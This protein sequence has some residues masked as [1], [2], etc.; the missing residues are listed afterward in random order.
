MSITAAHWFFLDV[1]FL[2]PALAWIATLRT[3]LIRAPIDHDEIIQTLLTAFHDLGGAAIVFLL[4]AKGEPVF[5][6]MKGYEAAAEAGE[7]ALGPTKLRLMTLQKN[8]LQKA[9]L[10][11]WQASGSNGKRPLDGIIMA[12]TPW[13]A[14][15]LG[16]TQKNTYVGYTGVANLLGESNHPWTVCQHP[17]DVKQTCQRVHFPSRSQ[18]EP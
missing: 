5:E 12:V 6:A 9:Y 3:D 18:T 14:G 15:R 16:T 10:D 13:A 11:R 4:K 8:Q 2:S 1:N 7:G 17:V